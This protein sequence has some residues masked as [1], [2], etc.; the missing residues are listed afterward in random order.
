M[1]LAQGQLMPFHISAVDEFPNVD[2]LDNLHFSPTS[3]QMFAD[4]SE[5]LNFLK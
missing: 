1:W 5:F 3:V 2:N 4:V